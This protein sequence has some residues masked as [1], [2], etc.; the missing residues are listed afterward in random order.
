MQSNNSNNNFITKYEY[1]IITKKVDKS[2]VQRI[3]YSYIEI[4][5]LILFLI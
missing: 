1:E 4:T 5:A 3:V 2:I